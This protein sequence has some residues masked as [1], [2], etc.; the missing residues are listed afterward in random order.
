MLHVIYRRFDL[1]VHKVQEG[2][3]IRLL[4]A[5]IMRIYKINNSSLEEVKTVVIREASSQESIAQMN[6][7][8]EEAV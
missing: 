1:Y 2:D 8:R 5:V 6:G 4:E 3:G 7:S